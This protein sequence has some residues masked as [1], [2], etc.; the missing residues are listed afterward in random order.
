MEKIQIANHKYICPECKGNGY[1]RI[2][3]NMIVQ[4]DTC[5]SQGEVK[6]RLTVLEL[7]ELVKQAGLQ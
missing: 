2:A 7:K 1:N 4:C 6:H 3:K 5:K